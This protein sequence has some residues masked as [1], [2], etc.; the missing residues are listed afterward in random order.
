MSSSHSD[1]P[2]LYIQV[3]H[4]KDQERNRGSARAA[5]GRQEICKHVRDGSASERADRDPGV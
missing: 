1:H 2:L 4:S 3:S 5:T